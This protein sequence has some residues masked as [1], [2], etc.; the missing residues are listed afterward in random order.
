[1]IYYIALEPNG[2]KVLCGTQA[3]AKVI[4]KE[5]TQIDLPTDKAGLMATYQE[6]LDT[7]HNLSLDKA[8]LRQRVEQ[9]TDLLSE[10]KM[11]DMTK[12]LVEP[13]YAHQQVAFEDAFA[14]FPIPKQLHFAALAMENA[15][16]H[17]QEKEG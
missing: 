11:S 10:D 9:S 7:I 3:E 14:G 2:R 17:Y 4:D 16:D 1:M 8:E 5:F 13:S 15:R 6:A 12:A